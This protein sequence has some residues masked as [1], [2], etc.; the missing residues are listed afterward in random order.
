MELLVCY[1]TSELVESP[2]AVFTHECSS[3][4]SSATSSRAWRG[5]TVSKYV[6]DLYNYTPVNLKFHLS[7]RALQCSLLCASSAG[8]VASLN[9]KCYFLIAEGDVLVFLFAVNI[10]SSV[11]VCGSLLDHSGVIGFSFFQSNCIG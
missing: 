8:W 3:A 1:Q 10:C 11:G 7:Y 6:L 9:V 5:W 4:R 2:L